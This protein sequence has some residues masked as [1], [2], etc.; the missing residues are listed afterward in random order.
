MAAGSLEHEP[1]WS[2]GWEPKPSPPCI[3][4]VV[5]FP[6]LGLHTMNCGFAVGLVEFYLFFA[7]GDPSRV[8]CHVRG[9]I[10]IHPSGRSKHSG[11][12]FCWLPEQDAVSTPS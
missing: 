6:P 1:A 10:S 2:Q 12:S 9:S 7:C 5:L 4:P 11:G 3:K 8:L